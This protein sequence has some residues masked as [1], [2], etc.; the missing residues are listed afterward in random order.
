MRNACDFG[1]LLK[2]D[3]Q[4]MKVTASSTFESVKGLKEGKRTTD[5][6]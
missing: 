5:K 4:L 6:R 1:G 3:R 2:I